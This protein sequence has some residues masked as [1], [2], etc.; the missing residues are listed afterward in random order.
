[1]TYELPSFFGGLTLIL[2]SQP[3]SN[4]QPSLVALCIRCMDLIIHV[5]FGKHAFEKL[6]Q[7]LRQL[8]A[9]RLHFP[10][11]RHPLFLS[12]H[13]ATDVALVT[14][15]VASTH[16]S[17]A[18]KTSS[19]SKGEPCLRRPDRPQKEREPRAGRPGAGGSSS[20]GSPQVH[21]LPPEQQLGS[22]EVQLMMTLYSSRLMFVAVIAN[23]VTKTT[24]FIQFDV[25]IKDVSQIF[26]HRL[27]IIHKCIPSRDDNT[28]VTFREA[29][30]GLAQR[31]PSVSTT[32]PF[33]A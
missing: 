22:Q 3:K 13:H 8:V 9:A 1:M 33:Y 24:R 29:A 10:L 4:L 14:A 32:L 26:V 21:P 7:P 5:R 28:P 18:L 17:L 11:I 15:L 23:E 16:K 31:F 25:S 30:I 2:K 19:H 6:D 20:A 27:Q 12:V